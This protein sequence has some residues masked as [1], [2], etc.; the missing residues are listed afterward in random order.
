MVTFYRDALKR[1]TVY[2]IEKQF[3]VNDGYGDIQRLDQTMVITKR[4]YTEEKLFMQAL[5]NDGIRGINSK[6][7]HFFRKIMKF[8]D[9]SKG[10]WIS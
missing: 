9:H 5:C 1:G 3:K 2:Y 10:V 8:M 4:P 6:E 7:I